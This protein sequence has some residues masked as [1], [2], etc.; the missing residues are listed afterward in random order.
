LK[1]TLSVFM[2]DGVGGGA[3]FILDVIFGEKTASGDG[4]DFFTLNVEG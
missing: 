4:I 3:L 2:V 1:L